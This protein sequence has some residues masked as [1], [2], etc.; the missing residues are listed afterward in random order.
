MSSPEEH[1][2]EIMRELDVN[3]VLV[4]FGGLT[5]YASDGEQYN[6][7]EYE[8]TQHCCNVSRVSYIHAYAYIGSCA[9]NT[10]CVNLMH[11]P[12]VLN[13]FVSHY[14][15]FVGKSMMERAGIASVVSISSV[16]SSKIPLGKAEATMSQW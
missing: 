8:E 14:I 12:E 11:I 10:V 16:N 13:N 2:Y 6:L 15:T 7:G 9:S 5:G 4:I 1:A 3:Y